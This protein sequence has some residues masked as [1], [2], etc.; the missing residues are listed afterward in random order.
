VTY[1]RHQNPTTT[2]NAVGVLLGLLLA[3][4]IGALLLFLV[5]G[6][7]ILD[8]EGVQVQIV[9]QDGSADAGD[10][11]GVGGDDDE[12]TPPSGGPAAPAAPG[13]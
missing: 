10:E 3:L 5:F 6:I 2:G 7:G 8:D 1:H 13:D 11:G 9:G 12:G 4:V